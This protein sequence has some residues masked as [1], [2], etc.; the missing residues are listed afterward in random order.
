MATK[1]TSGQY[2]LTTAASAERARAVAKKRLPRR[3]PVELMGKS[4]SENESEDGDKDVDESLSDELVMSLSP[5]DATIP[6]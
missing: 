2:Q 4:E 1:R 3:G 6:A 5:A